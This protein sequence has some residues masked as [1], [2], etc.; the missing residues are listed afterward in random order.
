MCHC[1]WLGQFDVNYDFIRLIIN[2]L[3]ILKFTEYNF[4]LDDI[5]IWE[6][7]I[8]GSIIRIHG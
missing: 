2:F 3:K 4:V 7:V 1:Y 8:L 6:I 5:Y